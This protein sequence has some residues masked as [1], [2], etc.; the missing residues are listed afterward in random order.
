MRLYRPFVF[1][2]LLYPEAIFRVK[3]RENVLYLTFDD[4]PD[5]VSTPLLLNIL[6]KNLIRAVFF[7]LG[8]AASENPELIKKIKSSGHILGNHGY[9]H[10]DGFL[11]SNHEYLENIR[12]ASSF[13][14]ENLMRPPYGRLRRK[15]YNELKKNYRIIMWDIMPYDFDR[16]FDSKRA[17]SILKKMIRPGSIIVLHDKQKYFDPDFIEKFIQ[18]AIDLGYGFDILPF[19]PVR[20]LAER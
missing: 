8:K 19:G 10:S 9:D 16:D 5:P 6:N 18:I 15:Q 13:T 12:K 3:T 7:C 2:K 17:L 14:S 4:G 20:P 1:A 11:S